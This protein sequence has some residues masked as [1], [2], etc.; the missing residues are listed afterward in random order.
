MEILDLMIE[1]DRYV[2][3]EGLD[4]ENTSVRDL[5]DSMSEKF[6]EEN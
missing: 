4:K 3:R 1:I 6:K 5:L 2:A